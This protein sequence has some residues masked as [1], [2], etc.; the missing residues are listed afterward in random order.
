MLGR[1]HL[2]YIANPHSLLLALHH[3]A[4]T[5]KEK[6]TLLIIDSVSACIVGGDWQLLQA[7]GIVLKQLVHIHAIPTVTT[8]GITSSDKAALGLSWTSVAETEVRLTVTSTTISTKTVQAR[9][10]RHATRGPGETMDIVISG[11]GIKCCSET[12]TQAKA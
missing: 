10:E 3:T 4:E 1:L 2:T 12:A 7:V 5:N 11:G 8:N 6:P 9:L